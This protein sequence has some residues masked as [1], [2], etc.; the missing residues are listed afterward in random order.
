MERA[1][2]LIRK[3]AASKQRANLLELK[4]EHPELARAFRPAAGQLKKAGE[5]KVVSG[6]KRGARWGKA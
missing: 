6:Q 3:A 5:I 2:S 4:G 1:I